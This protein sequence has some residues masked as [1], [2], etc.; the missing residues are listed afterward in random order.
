MSGTQTSGFDLVIQF[1]EEAYADLLGVF[2]GSGGLIGR[3]ADLIGLGETELFT[4]AL[5]IDRP[6]DVT[7]PPEA[8][9]VL[10]IYLGL[11]ENGGLA[12][13]R[14]VVGIAV[15]RS[16]PD[17]D[18]V[19]ID[20]ANRIYY[21]SVTIGGLEIPFPGLRAALQGLIPAV[22]VLPVPVDRTTTRATTIRRADFKIVDD[23]S[24]ADRDAT[25]AMLTFGGGA[26]GNANA[27]Q[28]F[29]PDGSRGAVG[30]FFPWL[31]RMIVGP[32]AESLGVAPSDFSITNTQLS[33]TRTVRV[34]EDKEVD[35]TALTFT[36]AEGA[37]QVQAQVSKS[38]LCYTASG[39]IGARILLEIRDGRLLASAEIDDPE[40]DLDIPWYCWVAAAAIGGLLGGLLAGIIGATVGAVLLPLLLWITTDVVEGTIEQVAANVADDINDALPDVDVPAFGVNI[41]FQEVFIDDVVLQARL[42]VTDPSPLRA[43][44]TAILHAGEGLDLD[45]GRVDEA[46]SA[47]VDVIWRG[48]GNSRRLE[49]GCQAG[50]ART[51]SN[52][53]SHLPRYRLYSYVYQAGTSIGLFELG[54]PNPAGALFGDTFLESR[55]VLA[56]RTNEGRYA[57]VQ[58][59]EVQDDRVRLRFKTFE[60]LQPAVQIV[61]GFQCRRPTL[62]SRDAEMTFKL[63]DQLPKDGRLWQMS[64]LP[65]P[66]QGSTATMAVRAQ[67]TAP[68]GRLRTVVQRPEAPIRDAWVLYT[69]PFHDGRWTVELP[70]LQRAYARLSA[71]ATGLRGTPRYIWQVGGQALADGTSG[72]LDVSGVEVSYTVQGTELLLEVES[73][74]R[75]ELY[76]QV[77]VADDK[78]CTVSAA[79][80]VRHDGKCRVSRRTIPTWQEFKAL[81][82]LPEATIKSGLVTRRNLELERP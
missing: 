81:Q 40:I 14:M 30:I 28:S 22:P 45:T 19:R 70:A 8:E 16:S 49:T 2:F 42:D 82:A 6:Q 3:I 79:H 56:V 13:V 29:V 74:A 11:G 35:L 59:I 18:T 44:G 66:E 57:L 15:D 71:V 36:L 51:G 73:D 12:T 46:G 61:G 17:R 55:Q 33:L 64:D 37:I 69:G 23:T 5:S 25:A 9:N 65:L 7:L 76:V 20:F 47:H 80:C 60:T 34:D 24:A 77:S 75:V 38:G 54:I 31:S 68:L 4:L 72:K 26:A 1:S 32:L 10:D 78:G 50:L 41:L 27:L 62:V 48:S 43:E 58:A 53:F 21:A 67:S 63:L 52:E 39:T